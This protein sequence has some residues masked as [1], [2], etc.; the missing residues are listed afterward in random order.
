[1]KNSILNLGKSLSK[2]EQKKVK[3]R[4][5]TQCVEWCSDGTCN[6]W[7]NFKFCPYDT[8]PCPF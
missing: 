4:E 1:M 6:C 2:M 5:G 3:G 8:D 7:S